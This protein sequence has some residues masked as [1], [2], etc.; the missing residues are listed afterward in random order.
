MFSKHSLCIL[1]HF[2]IHFI[3]LCL[4]KIFKF[5]M[6]KY[7][8]CSN[9][10]SIIQIA[11][12]WSEIIS[13]EDRSTEVS[14]SGVCGSKIASHEV[15]L[16]KMDWLEML[17]LHRHLFDTQENRCGCGV[18]IMISAKFLQIFVYVYERVLK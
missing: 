14:F 4:L 17:E 1:L 10:H 3:I 5:S 16:M 8:V 11:T 7:Q 15:P 18:I 6:A 13:Y 12:S 9:I 2:H